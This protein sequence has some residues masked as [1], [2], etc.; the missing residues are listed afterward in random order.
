MRERHIIMEFPINVSLRGGFAI[1][2]RWMLNYL[3]LSI[4]VCAS[5]QKQTNHLQMTL[6]SGDDDGGGSIL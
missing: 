6:L 1:E 2:F 4:R 3:A 5:I